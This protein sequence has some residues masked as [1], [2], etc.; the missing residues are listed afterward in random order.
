M[1]SQWVISWHAIL[2][3]FRIPRSV[4]LGITK[5][6]LNMVEAI[7]INLNCDTDARNGEVTLKALSRNHWK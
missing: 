6:S 1:G 5:Q 7:N 2:R 3:G 4:G